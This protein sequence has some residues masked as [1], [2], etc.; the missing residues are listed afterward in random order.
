MDCC[1]VMIRDSCHVCQH[2]RAVQGPCPSCGQQS[3]TYFGDIL[4]VRGNREVNKV[5]CENCKSEMQFIA[6]K[7]QVGGLL[8]LWVLCSIIVDCHPCSCGQCWHD[9]TAPGTIQHCP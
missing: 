5:N 8:L 1:S 9:G 3:S 7:R 2:D 6:P 4:T